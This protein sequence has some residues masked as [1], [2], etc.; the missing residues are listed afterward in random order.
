MRVLWIAILGFSSGRTAF[1]VTE[2]G[3][4]Y[5]SDNKTPLSN[6]HGVFDRFSKAGQRMILEEAERADSVFLLPY[7]KEVAK[8]TKTTADAMRAERDT[9]DEP[10][11]LACMMPE[12]S[13]D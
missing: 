4:P 3:N 13:E 9:C 6:E 10:D 1:V 5:N 11:W 2:G 12:D 7:S 8:A